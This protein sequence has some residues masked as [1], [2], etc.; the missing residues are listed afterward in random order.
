MLR[1]TGRLRRDV[2][3]R[4]GSERPDLAGCRDGRLGE[5]GGVLAA[6]AP[7]WSGPPNPTRKVCARGHQCGDRLLSGER[8]RG[9]ARSG[10]RALTSAIDPRSRAPGADRF[11]AILSTW[12]D[13]HGDRSVTAATLAP[14]V[15]GLIDPQGLGRQFVASAVAKRADIRIA[16]VV[17]TR[18]DSPGKWSPATYA[19]RRTAGPGDAGPP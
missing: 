14:T 19:L 13:A 15:L 11:A 16:G 5:A 10:S 6:P 3:C 1:F 4:R 2:A 17:L 9:R 8:A 18:Q 7:E 12:W